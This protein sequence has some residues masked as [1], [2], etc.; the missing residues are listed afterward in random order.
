[1]EGE[2]ERTEFNNFHL[3]F[4]R[5]LPEVGHFCVV[6]TPNHYILHEVVAG[7]ASRVGHFQS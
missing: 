1:M 7:L 3:T 2:K 5:L 4:E 6:N